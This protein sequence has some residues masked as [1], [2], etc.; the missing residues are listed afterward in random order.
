MN[1]MTNHQQP[2]GHG[3]NNNNMMESLKSNMMTMLM[4][5]NMNGSK[6]SGS[7]DTFTMVYVFIATSVVDFIFKNAPVVITPLTI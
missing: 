5:N 7:K 2:M 6:P 1:P 3:G 4:I